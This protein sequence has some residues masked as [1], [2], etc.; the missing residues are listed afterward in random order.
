MEELEREYIEAIQE[1]NKLSTEQ[2]LDE[3]LALHI[4][5]QKLKDAIC[6]IK[7]QITSNKNMVLTGNSRAKG[8][9]WIDKARQAL[10][11]KNKQLKKVNKKIKH[12]QNL[13]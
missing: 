10:L 9:E 12:I 3:Y 8:Q 4:K 13:L 1:D 7:L 6:S 5:R 11:I 2:M